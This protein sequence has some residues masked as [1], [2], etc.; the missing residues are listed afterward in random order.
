MVLNALSLALAVVVLDQSIKE[1]VVRKTSR[2]GPRSH[3]WPALSH[4]TNSHGGVAVLA[5]RQLIAGWSAA[6]LGCVV[7]LVWGQGLLG[8]IGIAGLAIALGGATGNL[9]DLVRRGGI[10]DYVSLGWWPAFNLADAMIVAGVALVL[11]GL[12]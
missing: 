5:P 3:D 4:V 6:L 2:W 11:W 7:L 9:I 8:S 10:V 1:A 12:G